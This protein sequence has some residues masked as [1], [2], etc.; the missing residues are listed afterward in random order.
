MVIIFHFVGSF[1][2]KELSYCNY[3]KQ[4]ELITHFSSVGYRG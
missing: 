3:I 1:N 4:M 2:I